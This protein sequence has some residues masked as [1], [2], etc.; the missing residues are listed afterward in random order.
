MTNMTA[1]IL[2]CLRMPEFNVNACTFI[3]QT[4]MTG[5]SGDVLIKNLAPAV[6]R[7]KQAMTEH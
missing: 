6:L 5:T 7:S 4:A 2:T 1:G 3:T